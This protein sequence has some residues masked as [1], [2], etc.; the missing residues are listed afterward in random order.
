MARGL[1][2]RVAVALRSY[3]QLVANLVRILVVLF[4]GYLLFATSVFAEGT[5][6]RNYNVGGLVMDAVYVLIIVAVAWSWRRTKS[7]TS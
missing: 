7:R 3:S 6:G 5:S 1:A 2:A 4:A